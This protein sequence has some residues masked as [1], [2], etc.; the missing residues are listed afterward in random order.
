[1]AFPTSQS[2]LIAYFNKPLE[3][4]E[5]IP[6][7]HYSMTTLLSRGEPTIMCSED[8]LRRI[9]RFTEDG[10]A[11]YLWT[12]LKTAI[13]T[14][15]PDGDGTEA[16]FISFWDDNIRK[17]LSATFAPNQVVRDSNRHASTRRQRP[18]F[19]FL[20]Y[21]VCIFRGEEKPPNYSGKHP[22]EELFQKL[23]WTYHPAPW[24]LGNATSF[25][26]C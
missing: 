13:V 17:I 11:D 22:K 24:I 21:G 7:S 3:E 10:E 9:F 8:D 16:S 4:N 1:M 6:L 25:V 19:G 18:D 23:T 14:S 12:I 26:S 5:K 2:D 20:K 15:A